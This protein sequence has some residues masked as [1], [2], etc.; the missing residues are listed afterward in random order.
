MR[1]TTFVRT[2]F[3]CISLFFLA[4][5][6]MICLPAFA[7][8]AAP[9]VAPVKDVPAAAMPS[10]PKELMLLAAKTNGL[11]GDDVKPWHLKA[12]FTLFD[13]SGSVTNQGTYEEFW[14]SP[15]KFKRSYQCKSF[16]QTTYGTG[17]DVLRSGAREF[18]PEPFT[19]VRDEIV[20]PIKIPEKWTEHLSSKRLSFDNGGTKF[21][22]LG[23]EGLS[24][25]KLIAGF[26][27][28]VYCMDAYSPALRISMNWGEI[29]QF[30]LDNIV[31]F[32]GHDLPG[33]LEGLRGGKP[34]IK[35]HLDTA[36]TLKTVSEAD[37]APPAD[38]TP[39]LPKVTISS[40][41]AQGLEIQQNAPVYPPIA[42]AARVE[43]TVELSAIIGVDGHILFLRVISGPAMLWQ[44]TLD[45]VKKWT[46][47]PCLLN[48]E[49][50]EVSTIIKV[51]FPHAGDVF[52]KDIPPGGNPH[53]IP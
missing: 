35:L 4:T 31:S 46:Y 23:H 32:Q 16:K 24:G 45:A 40:A 38:A 47:K 14:A 25:L 30:N 42:R 37:F 2:L 51:I 41:V 10:D 11:T 20:N 19:Q 50:V 22:C 27:P 26:V 49:P 9:A 3:C 7:Q 52:T 8:D 1:K 5:F 44:A 17:N 6:S 33:D 36:E 43:G 53:A 48:N 18:F 21:H 12:S 39:I 29:T 13:E 28:P 15:V 34:V